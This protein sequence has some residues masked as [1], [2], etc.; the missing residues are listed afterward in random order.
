MSLY[1]KLKFAI[2]ENHHHGN[3]LDSYWSACK[4]FYRF[5][6]KPASQWTSLTLLEKR[7]GRSH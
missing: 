3:T 2:A 4:K 1:E 7:D 5:C 6:G